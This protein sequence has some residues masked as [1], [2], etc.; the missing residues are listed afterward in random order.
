MT[1]SG[2]A[3]RRR[4]APEA[5]TARVQRLLTMV[6]WLVSR[7]GISVEEASVGLG[8]SK[9]QLVDDL[10][11]IF[12]CGTGS[13]PD[14][15]I[16]A[17]YEHGRV[18]VSNADTIRR[19]RQLGVDEAISLI[20]GLQALRGLGP[21]PSE[22]VERALAKLEAA[23]GQITGADRVAV[24]PDDGA[25][26]ALLDAIATAR[27]E[28][29]RLHLTYIVPSRDERTERDVDP[30][31]AVSYD[32][33]WYLEGWCHRA[34]ATRLFRLD[35]VEHLEVLDTPGVPPEE[36]LPR[37]LSAGVYQGAEDDHLVTLRL[38]PGARWVAEYYPVRE[39]EPLE[40]GELRVVLPVGDLRWL[41]ALALRLGGAGVVEGPPEAVAAVATAAGDT[42]AGYAPHG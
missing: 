26:P 10:Q 28:G 31:R 16:E 42:L 15:L 12:M 30:L 29:R 25:D 32:G 3:P 1:A 6:P 5:A 23:T 34:R 40:G 27:R 38:G 17:S 39:T 37:D 9:Q 19:P 2:S 18:F 35:R 11:L 24:A 4:K 13:M 36:V 14:E 7:Q 41:S 21:E 22:A 33:H 8:I 20:I